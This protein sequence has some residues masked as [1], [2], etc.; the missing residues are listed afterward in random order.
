VRVV[1]MLIVV[2]VVS[3][4]A[5]GVVLQEVHAV[6]HRAGAMRSAAARARV[7]TML[8]SIEQ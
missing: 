8:S 6:N 2:S 4:V 1:N 5:V 3:V 7:S